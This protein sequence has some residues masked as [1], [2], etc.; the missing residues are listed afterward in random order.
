MT[1]DFF[2][3]IVPIFLIIA[4]CDN[5]DDNGEELDAPGN[6]SF[7]I[8]GSDEGAK[9]GMASLLEPSTGPVFFSTNDIGPQTFSMNFTWGSS[10]SI[11]GEGTYDITNSF[12]ASVGDAFWVVYTNTENGEEFG[13]T[14]D[15]TGTLE[16]TEFNRDFVEGIF[17]FTAEQFDGDGSITVTNGTFTAV[18]ETN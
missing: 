2:V 16:I 18:N 9:E 4:S 14:Q 8:S 17:S 5:D 1:K 3:L 15:V 7:D 6:V 11:P 12:S 10:S 13:S